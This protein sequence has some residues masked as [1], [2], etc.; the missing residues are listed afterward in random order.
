MEAKRR[1]YR[2]HA[3]RSEGLGRDLEIIVSGPHGHFGEVVWEYISTAGVQTKGGY[4]IYKIIAGGGN[5]DYLGFA[6]KDLTPKG[7]ITEIH[8]N[9]PDRPSYVELR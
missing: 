3:T 8:A 2:C 5:P 7:K 4:T 9:E 1:P 6:G